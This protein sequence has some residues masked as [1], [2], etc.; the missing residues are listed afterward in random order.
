MTRPA[1]ATP[2]SWVVCASVALAG[3]GAAAGSGAVSTAGDDS[4]DPRADLP[5]GETGVLVDPAPELDGAGRVGLYLPGG[6]DRHG[7]AATLAAWLLADAAPL[8]GAR[9]TAHP[10]AISVRA[11]CPGDEL[12]R[13]IQALRDLRRTP[14]EV[15]PGRLDAL[16]RDL[17]RAR[18]DRDGD[19]D[20][21]A[22]AA[23]VTALFPT[24]PGPLPLGPV[25]AAPEPVTPAELEVVLGDLRAGPAVIAV[26]GDVPSET[27]P[28]PRPADAPA[29][30]WAPSGGP[31]VARVWSVRS[32]GASPGAVAL[33]APSPAAVRAATEEL[34]VAGLVSPLR[35]DAIRTPWGSLAVLSAPGG[36]EASGWVASLGRVLGSFDSTARGPVPATAPRYVPGGD[37]VDA[38]LDGMGLRWAA[39]DPRPDGSA[40]ADEAP[41]PLAFGVGVVRDL[42]ARAAQAPDH[43]PWLD[44]ELTRRLAAA[45]RDA[46]HPIERLRERD[47]EAVEVSE[48]RATALAGGVRVEARR[49]GSRGTALLIGLAGGAASV[50]THLWSAPAVDVAARALACARALPRADVQPLV[51]SDGRGLA[52]RFPGSEGGGT[53]FLRA[54][55]CAARDPDPVDVA[56]VLDDP[57]PPSRDRVARAWVATTVA[58]AAPGVIAPVPARLSPGAPDAL[59]GRIRRVVVIGDRPVEAL[60]REVLPWLPLADEGSSAAQGAPP[61]LRAPAGPTVVT[62]FGRPPEER[63]PEDPWWALAV[64][65]T[66]APAGDEPRARAGAVVG[67]RGFARAWAASWSDEEPGRR[68]PPAPVWTGGGL[69]PGGD[70]WSAVVMRVPRPADRDAFSRPSASLLRGTVTDLVRAHREEAGSPLGLGRRLL[71]AAPGRAGV[72]EEMAQRVAERLRG[73]AEARPVL[74]PA[75]GL[76]VD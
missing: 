28:P 55:A 71:G 27:P 18:R 44:E 21:L 41:G 37:G 35:S 74:L 6:S 47:P 66:A 46:R 58:P 13:C 62:R 26:L 25:S 65:R 53:P 52:F 22:A 67:A 14:T 48:G 75:G 50:P 16:W 64:V 72:D 17:L 8:D 60:L 69:L 54:L 61:A 4:R 3:C 24:P 11:P 33:A 73:A 76:P 10:H 70:V 2:S 7:V 1:G 59:P 49:Q 9:G 5:P 51:W 39:G 56:R 30:L 23:A 20:R 57:P 42:D 38:R 15:P 19:A 32:E 31:R 68:A 43:P 45:Q 36:R 34:L 29:T 63:G 12:P 40:G